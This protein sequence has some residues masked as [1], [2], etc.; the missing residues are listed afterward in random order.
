MSIR[1]G[2][3]QLATYLSSTDQ[4]VIDQGSP[5]VTKRAPIGLLANIALSINDQTG[6][7]YTLVLA[8]GIQ[9]LIRMNNA[10]P[11][12][13]TIPNSSTVTFPVGTNILLQRL[14][15]GTLTIAGAGG[16]T[17]QTA[18]TLTARAQYSMLGLIQTA[19]NTWVLMGDTS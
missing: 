16:V 13:L 4:M 14:G 15:A 7:T 2:Q 9:R 18:S 3:L 11:M 8:D 1:I 12:T 17:V 19:L 6:T 10:S 5:P